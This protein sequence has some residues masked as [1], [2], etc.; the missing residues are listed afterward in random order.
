MNWILLSPDL[1]EAIHD[2]VLNPGELQGRARDKSLEAAL[3][4][5]DNRL[6]YGM[7]A[8]VFDLAAAYAIAVARGHCFN[9]GNKRSAFRVMN[10][11]LALNGVAMT[12]DTIDVGQTIIRAAQG[13][14][15][16]P[17]L[18]DW[19]RLKAPA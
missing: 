1:V 7:V 2:E 17:D 12:W 14:L 13:L 11:V 8:D 15:E 18:A 9:D 3:A 4:R 5:V 6:A 10:A 19:L 16:E